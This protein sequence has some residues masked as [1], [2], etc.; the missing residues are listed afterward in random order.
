[1]TCSFSLILHLYVSLHFVFLT[2]SPWFSFCFVST[3]QEIEIVSEVTYFGVLCDVY[4]KKTKKTTKLKLKKLHKLL[5][6]NI[7]GCCH[8]GIN[9]LEFVTRAFKKFVE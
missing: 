4:H 9:Y 8:A 3:S 2:A 1:V 5:S 7:G 6:V